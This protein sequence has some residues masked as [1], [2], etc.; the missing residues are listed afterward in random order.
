MNFPSGVIHYRVTTY[1]PTRIVHIIFTSTR[2]GTGSVVLKMTGSTAGFE[3]SS[4]GSNNTE[5]FV[6]GGKSLTFLLR[7]PT[8]FLTNFTLANGFEI[9]SN[10][11][12]YSVVIY[13]EESVQIEVTIN[14]GTAVVGLTNTFIL[15][16]TN[17]C[18]K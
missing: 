2:H 18:V 8:S 12:P 4:S 3:L 14:S 6:S 16:A 15:H 10:N 9:R 7:N 11:L 13:P 1:H 5:I 17:G